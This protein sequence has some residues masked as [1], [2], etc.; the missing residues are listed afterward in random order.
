MPHTTTGHLVLSATTLIDDKVKNPAGEDLG[1]ITEIMLDVDSGRIAY[2][3]LSFGGFMGLG[4]KLFAIPWEALEL[5][6]EDRRFVLNID[7][8]VLADAQGFDQDRWPNMADP[9]WSRRIHA[10]YGYEPYWTR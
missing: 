1:H 2:A 10:H 3:V 6:T 9:E 4:D 7:Q 8:T 5:D